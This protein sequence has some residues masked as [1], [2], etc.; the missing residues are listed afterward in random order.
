VIEALKYVKQNSR[1]KILTDSKLVAN[2]LR[3]EWRIKEKR[4]R[5][6]VEEVFSIIEKKSLSFEIEWIPRSENKVG[7]VLG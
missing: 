4:L 7:K 3:M 5:L 2:Q 6:L 1:V